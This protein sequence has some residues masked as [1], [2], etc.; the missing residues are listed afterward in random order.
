MFKLFVRIGKH[1]WLPALYIG[2][3]FR[4]GSKTLL[5]KEKCA[6]THKSVYTNTFALCNLLFLN[7]S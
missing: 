5:L 1:F 2:F 6:Y 4:A 3:F 7:I